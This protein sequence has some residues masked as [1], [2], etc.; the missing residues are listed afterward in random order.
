MWSSHLN[1]T[2][3]GEAPDADTTAATATP[4]TSPEG[5]QVPSVQVQH[6]LM[7]GL[8]RRQ[9]L[10]LLLVAGITLLVLRARRP[11]G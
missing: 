10:A 7:L 5:T 3:L 1:G 4:S 11:R 2:Y 6:P 9:W 8:S